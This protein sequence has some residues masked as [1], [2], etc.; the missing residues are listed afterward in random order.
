MIRG[1]VV[2]IRNL[3]T[4]AEP[5]QLEIGLPA[6]FLRTSVATATATAEEV[7]H[8]VEQRVAPVRAPLR[9]LFL[10]HYFPPEVNAPASRTYEMCKRWVRSGHQVRVVTCAPNCPTGL[11]YDGYRNK[12]DQ[13]ETIDGIKVVR[14]WTFVAANKGK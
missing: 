2:T 6:D 11:V 14:L 5:R 13:S 10:T 3:E 4:E 12:L 1:G 8:F 7:N 9:I